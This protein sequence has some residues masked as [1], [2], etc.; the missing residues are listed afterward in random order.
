MWAISSEPAS[1]LEYFRES[2]GLSLPILHDDG[3]RV[4]NMYAQQM[5]FPTGAYPQE[6]LV[7]RDGTIV[8]TNN[9]F[10]AEG[11]RAAIEAALA[12]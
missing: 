6:V 3:S 11:L 5:A 10:E 8:Y 12:Q 4:F 7:G 9:R 1:Q 2:Y